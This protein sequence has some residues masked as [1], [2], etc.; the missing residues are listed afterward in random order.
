MKHLGDT[1]SVENLQRV[2]GSV[3]I[4]TVVTDTFNLFFTSILPVSNGSLHFRHLSFMILF[5]FCCSDICIWEGRD[6]TSIASF[7]R[8]VL[9]IFD[10][11]WIKLIEIQ[12]RGV[13]RSGIVSVC[14]LRVVMVAFRY[15]IK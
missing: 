14:E 11:Q 10:F 13:Y 1:L 15:G 12:E 7:R 6:H 8:I 2:H 9:I 3:Q 5:R 4:M